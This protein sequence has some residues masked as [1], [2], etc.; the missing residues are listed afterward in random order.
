MISSH[1]KIIHCSHRY[2]LLVENTESLKIKKKM[3]GL[4][5]PDKAEKYFKLN[6]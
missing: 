1:G 2:S 6:C 5:I 3:S 4:N